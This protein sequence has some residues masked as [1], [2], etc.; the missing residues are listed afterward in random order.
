MARRRNEEERERLLQ[1]AYKLMAEQGF[2]NTSLSD[3][4]RAA[5]ITKS[6]VQYYFPAKEIL[7]TTLI[8]RGLNKI[9]IQLS[10]DESLN[11][12][13]V[14]VKAFGVGYVLFNYSFFNPVITNYLID[15]YLENRLYTMMVTDS[16]LDW[17]EKTYPKLM[18]KL[19]NEDPHF[20]DKFSFALGG[21]I[22]YVYECR[23]TNSEIDGDFIIK[24]ALMQLEPSLKVLTDDY[25][26]ILEI[27]KYI[28]KEWISEHVKEY[29]KIMFGV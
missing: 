17:F 16:G 20:A 27:D 11:F 6:L 7:A 25:K 21:L 4:A 3:I 12:P 5:N 24:F 26:D 8:D 18:H 19:Y 2:E 23:E 1:V 10:D 13:S 22:Q 28:S 9:F 14:A 29:N 15:E